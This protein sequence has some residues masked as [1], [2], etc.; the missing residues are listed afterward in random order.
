MHPK[1]TTFTIEWLDQDYGVEKYLV[2]EKERADI[3]KGIIS[4]LSPLGKALLDGRNSFLAPDGTLLYRIISFEYPL[5]YIKQQRIL[6]ERIRLQEELLQLKTVIHQAEIRI[7]H[8]FT[9]PEL[10][11]LDLQLAI[12]WFEGEKGTT[13]E[14]DSSK[15]GSFSRELVQKMGSDYDLGKMLSAR[16]A[17]V[18]A[19]TA[20]RVWGYSQ[21]RDISVQQIQNGNIQNHDWLTCDL[22]VD[23]IPYDVKNS[24]R[25]RKNPDIYS[26]HIIPR[27]KHQRGT[28]VNIL[29]VLSHYLRPKEILFPGEYVT[30]QATSLRVLGYTEYKRL[31]YLEKYFGTQL[32]L[33]F[34]HPK[35]LPG[36]FLPPWI[37]EY[38]ERL[39]QKRQEAINQLSGM[40]YQK[41]LFDALGYAPIPLYLASNDLSNS[42]WSQVS[43]L[44]WQRNFIQKIQLWNREV[45]LSLP[46]LFLT[47]ITHFIEMAKEKNNQYRPKNYIKLLYCTGNYDFPLFIYDPLRTVKK[48]IDALNTIWNE[49]RE[50]LFE[51]DEF[52]LQSTG[53]LRGKHKKIN[54]WHTLLAYCGGWVPT[55]DENGN[56][57]YN[58][59]IPCGTN[60]LVL[61]NQQLCECGK[62][63]CGCGY[64][65][66]NCEHREKRQQE[67]YGTRIVQ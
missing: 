25:P 45:G 42:F 59:S 20:F 17:E 34:A 30:Y 36:K 31:Q 54:Q 32:D 64:C 62:L 51:Y 57:Q 60:P 43:V 53:I 65:S 40:R 23:D 15:E 3:Q 5:A 24:R 12:K 37:F 55:K 18:V 61:G 29:G 14:I 6:Q 11:K 56:W 63:I 35:G 38:P 7:P 46:F 44:N 1:E 9:M 39:Y 16:A 49:N 4:H 8:N 28:N 58:Q 10:N 48:L 33:N 52:K 22:L 26:E 66:D 13:I 19:K 47:L 27:F 41:D 2:S 21:I 50:A 67:M